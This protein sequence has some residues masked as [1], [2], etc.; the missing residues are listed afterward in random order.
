MKKTI[1]LVELICAMALMGVIIFAATSMDIAARRFFRSSEAE[2]QAVNEASYV[3]EHIQNNLSLAH[4][5]LDAAGNYTGVDPEPVFNGSTFLE[6]RIDDNH[7]PADASDDDLIRY[8]RNGNN[9]EFLVGG[10]IQ[11]TLSDNITFL[12]FD[13]DVNTSVVRVTI[14]AIYD[15]SRA[16]DTMTNPEVLLISNVFLGQHSVN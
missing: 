5:W 2:A 6:V 11:E 16:V 14:R 4:G 7:T 13:S 1:T 10:V 9:V 12:E 8:Q 3:M 15:T